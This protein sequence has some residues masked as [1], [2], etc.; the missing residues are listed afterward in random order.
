MTAAGHATCAKKGK[1]ESVN[2]GTSG[3]GEVI[4]LSISRIELL[5]KDCSKINTH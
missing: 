3:S 1:S 4:A 2:A 5:D